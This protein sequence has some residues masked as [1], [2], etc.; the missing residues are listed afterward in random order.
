VLLHGLLLAMTVVLCVLARL[1]C[2]VLPFLH[3]TTR[4]L[5]P[6]VGI[7]LLYVF[8]IVFQ[9]NLSSWGLSAAM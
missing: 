5:I 3:N 7:G 2:A 9:V 4:F 6:V 1:A 8:T